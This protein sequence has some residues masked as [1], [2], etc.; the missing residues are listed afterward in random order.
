MTTYESL[1]SSITDPD[2]GPR[3]LRPHRPAPAHG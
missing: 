3:R 2:G 1:R